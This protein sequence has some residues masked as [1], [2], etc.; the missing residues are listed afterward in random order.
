MINYH[1]DPE[2]FFDIEPSVVGDARN[3]CY[4][5]RYHV[6]DDSDRTVFICLYKSQ[7]NHELLNLLT[8][9]RY[10]STKS[11]AHTPYN[12]CF[13]VKVNAKNK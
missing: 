5:S 13:F 12:L 4:R 11:E 7:M 10:L 6:R 2:K 8:I 1:L 3:L 9:V